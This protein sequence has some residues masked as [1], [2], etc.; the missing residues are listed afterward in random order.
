MLSGRV[1]WKTRPC[2]ITTSPTVIWPA[3]TCGKGREC[4]SQERKLWRGAGRAPHC[5][6]SGET[7]AKGA[8]GAAPVCSA[9]GV[10]RRPT[11]LR[12]GMWC[13]W[14]PQARLVGR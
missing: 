4:F 7:L 12:G 3:S 1:S 8:R 14:P 13:G 2:T 9:E 11:R 5:R 10:R 6:G